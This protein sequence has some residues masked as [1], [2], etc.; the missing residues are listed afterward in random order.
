MK[1]IVMKGAMF[2]LILAGS[3]AFNSCG[4]KNKGA[5]NESDIDTTTIAAPDMEMDTEADT[6]T[7]NP[8]TIM[9]P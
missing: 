7:V 3:L 1:A 5:E 6:V 2:S 4:D 8:D 9:G